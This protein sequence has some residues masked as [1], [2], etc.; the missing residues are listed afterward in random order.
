MVN[1]GKWK[2]PGCLR[3]EKDSEKARWEDRC[4]KRGEWGGVI[5]GM[6]V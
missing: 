4:G 6:E 3:E 5:G 2:W 1:R